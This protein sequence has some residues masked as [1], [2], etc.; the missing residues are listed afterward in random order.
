VEGG[1]VSTPARS[2]KGKEWNRFSGGLNIVAEIGILHAI[3][4][5]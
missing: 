5:G 3:K 4:K 2:K 1:A